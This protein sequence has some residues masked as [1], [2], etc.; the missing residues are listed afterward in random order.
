MLDAFNIRDVRKNMEAG[1]DCNSITK[2]LLYESARPSIGH[3]MAFVVSTNARD[4]S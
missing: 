1:A 4:T 3:H 2:P